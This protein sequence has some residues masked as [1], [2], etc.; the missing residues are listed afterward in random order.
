M[1]P[2]EKSTQDKTKY[3][4]SNKFIYYVVGQHL[5]T[6]YCASTAVAAFWRQHALKTWQ[7]VS[8]LT[9]IKDNEI[10]LPLVLQLKASN[11]FFVNDF[12]DTLGNEW[13]NES[14]AMQAYKMCDDPN[15]LVS[16]HVIVTKGN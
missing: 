5:Q 16:I 14:G 8:F 2:Q 10:H 11:S 13:M 6:L 3:I 9:I 1:T 7:N 15:N 12:I 4:F